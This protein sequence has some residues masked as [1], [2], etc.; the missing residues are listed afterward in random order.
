MLLSRS[1]QNI[2]AK[3]HKTQWVCL[4]SVSFIALCCCVFIIL[5]TAPEQP[6][7]PPPADMASLDSGQSGFLQQE[8]AGNQVG[9]CAFGTFR[10][11]LCLSRARAPVIV[12]LVVAG[13]VSV[14]V[15]HT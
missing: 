13:V 6:L 9:F 8:D 3:Q 15:F 7:K 5:C 12:E 1:R 2:C 4:A 14:D 10:L 11:C